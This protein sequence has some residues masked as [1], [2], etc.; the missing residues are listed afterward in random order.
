MFWEE[1]KR[2]KKGEQGR[3]EMIKDGNGQIFRDGVEVRW[4][5]AE[6]FEQVLNGQMTGRQISI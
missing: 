1:V 2:V 6:Y 4:R 5:W 3:D